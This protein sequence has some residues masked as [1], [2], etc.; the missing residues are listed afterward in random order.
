MSKSNW[1][2]LGPKV[3][4][5]QVPSILISANIVDAR[6]EEIEAAIKKLELYR[7]VIKIRSQIEKSLSG[8]QK[9]LLDNERYQEILNEIAESREFLE[10]LE[11]PEEFNLA[12]DI[13]RDTF[14][15]EI[16]KKH[17]IKAV[18]DARQH[19]ATLDTIRDAEVLISALEDELEQIQVEIEDELMSGLREIEQDLLLKLYPEQDVESTDELEKKPTVDVEVEAPEVD[20]QISDEPTADEEVEAPEDDEQIPD[21]P[22]VDVEV[23]APEVDEQISDEPTADEEVEA[24]EDDEQFSDEPT[25]EEEV[26]APE[27]DEQISD[28][29]AAEE[30]VEAHEVDEQIS[31]EPTAEEEVETPEDDEQISDDPVVAPEVETP[32]P[33]DES[34]GDSIDT[35]EPEKQKTIIDMDSLIEFL[36]AEGF[37]L[38]SIQEIVDSIDE[39]DNLRMEEIIKIYSVIR[40]YL[41]EFDS[42]DDLPNLLMQNPQIFLDNSSEIIEGRIKELHDLFDAEI[43]QQILINNLKLLLGNHIRQ[44]Y[45]E[46]ITVFDND[47]ELLVA[48]LTDHIEAFQ[49]HLILDN[50]KFLRD[51]FPEKDAL[52][53][54]LS[55][56]PEI[57][58]NDELLYVLKTL[59]EFFNDDKSFSNFIFA[60]P[61][62]LD[63]NVFTDWYN[64]VLPLF[65]DDS[66]L[67]RRCIRREN[68]FL[69]LSVEGLTVRMNNFKLMYPDESTFADHLYSST[70]LFP[71][72]Q[73]V[74]SDNT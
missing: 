12:D 20:E 52:N 23:E 65:S 50:L 1:L 43:T 45:E 3:G 22:T 26:E 27:V 64:G 73:L 33:D 8:L 61:N 53:E 72:N 58:L 11:V 48:F 66:N 60:N 4:E 69:T 37:E 30:E 18:M 71:N 29:P 32:I 49:F 34:S 7:E 74:F 14:L 44:G 67:L 70:S 15:K 41:G 57:L 10:S 51:R 62:F 5:D 17:G 6:Q 28:E 35:Q 24:P 31:D 21:E 46:L 16:R 25:A 19:L 2:S 47:H 63:S 42:E 54:M 55:N 59:R 40:D 36:E 68:G 13:Q 56:Y 39:E 9:R 38:E